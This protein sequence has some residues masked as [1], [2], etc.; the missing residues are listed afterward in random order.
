MRLPGLSLLIFDAS[1]AV[2]ACRTKIHGRSGI[3][4]WIPNLSKT[5]GIV[6]RVTGYIAPTK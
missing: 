1:T 3:V 6:A 5:S 2:I 4:E